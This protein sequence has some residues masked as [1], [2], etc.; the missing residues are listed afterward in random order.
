MNTRNL[1]SSASLARWAVLGAPALLVASWL[2]LARAQDVPAATLPSTCFEGTSLTPYVQPVAFAPSPAYYV[3]AYPAAN[4]MM[5][6]RV[7]NG[8]REVH[9]YTGYVMAFEADYIA[10]SH[11]TVF[12]AT[13]SDARCGPISNVYA[14][15]G[16]V[17]DGA[18]AVRH[19]WTYRSPH[20][21]AAFHRDICDTGASQTIVVMEGNH[22]LV[23]TDGPYAPDQDGRS[24]PAD[25]GAR[26]QCPTFRWTAAGG[27]LAAG[28]Q[29]CG[30]CAELD[31]S[32]CTDPCFRTPGVMHAG[33]CDLTRAL[34]LCDLAAGQVCSLSGTTPRC[35][36]Y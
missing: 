14:R 9:V 20:A 19:P 10:T 17:D 5:D 28:L 1:R 8:S 31:G 21:T 4:G 12:V 26:M 36:A 30:S 3:K 24:G 22:P 29:S 27:F 33:Q 11:S 7:A 2:G 16:Q 23:P 35:V 13:V 15:G 18:I 25:Y 32:A 34:P 6:V